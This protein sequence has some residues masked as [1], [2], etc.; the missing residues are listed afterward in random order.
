MNKN[1]ND[2]QRNHPVTDLKVMNLSNDDVAYKV[3]IKAKDSD[4]WPSVRG[5][6]NKNEYMVFVDVKHDNDPEFY[7]LSQKQWGAVL[8]EIL[9]NRD[10]GA[11]IVDGAIEWNWTDKGQQK[12]RRGSK[13][14][15]KEISR[16]KDNWSVLPGVP[17]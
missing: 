4:S 5:V 10:H 11:E 15:P 7:I 2:D 6:Q 12:K 16:Y 17:K 8:R 1:L 3:S 14:Y 13:L 9:P